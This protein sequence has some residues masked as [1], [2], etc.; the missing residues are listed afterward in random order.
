MK[1]MFHD[2]TKPWKKSLSNNHKPWENPLRPYGTLVIVASKLIVES[3]TISQQAVHTERHSIL[4][5][6]A[7]P[8]DLTITIIYHFVTS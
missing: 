1:K 6:P 4:P 5:Q 7:L 2:V 8:Y 3:F